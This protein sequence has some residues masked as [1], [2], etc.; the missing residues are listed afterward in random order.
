MASVLIFRQNRTFNL[1]RKNIKFLTTFE[2][3]VLAS[4]YGTM[5]CRRNFSLKKLSVRVDFYNLSNKK[6]LMTFLFDPAL[7]ENKNL[8]SLSA[9]L[10]NLSNNKLVACNEFR[11]II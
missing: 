7:D 5:L 2:P 8:L 11:P 3:R 9:T 4:I 6:N 10:G 1:E